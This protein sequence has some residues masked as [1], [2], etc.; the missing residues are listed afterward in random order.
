MYDLVIDLAL[1]A[2]V[3]VLIATQLKGTTLGARR[4]LALPAAVVILGVV[5]L[6][7]QQHLRP[8]DDVYLAVSAAVAA[9][10]GLAQGAAMRLEQRGGVL[11]GRLPVWG[12]WLWGALLASRVAVYALADSHGAQPAASFGAVLLALGI[13]RAAQSA[14]VT[15]RAYAAG[16]PLADRFAGAGFPGRSTVPRRADS[17]AGGTWPQ[18]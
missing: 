6:A 9:A 3:I 13:N 8:I 4:L 15:G 11:W 18:W 2:A 14:V 17:R 5:E 16:I 1:V 7:G 12:L 10:I